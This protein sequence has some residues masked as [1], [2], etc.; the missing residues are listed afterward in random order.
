MIRKPKID[1]TLQSRFEVKGVDYCLATFPKSR[2]EERR[3]K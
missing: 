1:D 2:V 3:Q